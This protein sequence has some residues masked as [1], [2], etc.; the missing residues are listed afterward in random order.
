[1]FVLVGVGSRTEVY[2]STPGG[3][4]ARNRLFMKSLGLSS[5]LFV[6]LFL[7]VCLFVVASVLFLFQIYSEVFHT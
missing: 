7:F 5:F 3:I 4:D 1:M 2:S 6:F